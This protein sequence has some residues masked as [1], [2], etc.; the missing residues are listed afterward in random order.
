MAE[1]ETPKID[2]GQE[3]LSFPNDRKP[4]DEELEE[5][6]ITNQWLKEKGPYF[7]ACIL[8]YQH[9]KINNDLSPSAPLALFGDVFREFDGN[10]AIKQDYISRAEVWLRKK[11]PDDFGNTY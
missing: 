10:R 4:K 8:L 2:R 5:T 7:A 1:I 11:F 6:K 3:R 9:W